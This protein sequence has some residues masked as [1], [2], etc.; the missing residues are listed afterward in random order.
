M[1]K[2]LFLLTSFC[3]IAAASFA[4]SPTRDNSQKHFDH[5]V[6]SGTK[7]ETVSSFDF[8]A[9]PSAQV[10]VN[11]F[12]TIPNPDNVLAVFHSADYYLAQGTEIM[13][14]RT[15]ICGHSRDSLFSKAYL[16]KGKQRLHNKNRKLIHKR[17]LLKKDRT[18][19]PYSMCGWI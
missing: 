14:T 9:L 1:K 12:T 8:A 10:A 19:I 7:T 15:V 4:F 13:T 6:K 2:I 3:L 17:K 5:W 18:M 11:S 16:Q